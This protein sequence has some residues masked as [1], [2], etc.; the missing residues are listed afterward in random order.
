MSP[1]KT[2]VIGLGSM[3]KNHARILQ[4]MPDIELVGLV[5]GDGETLS[6]ASEAFSCKGYRTIEDLPD[7][8]I[9]YAVVA[10]PNSAHKQATCDMLDRQCHVLVEKPIAPTVEEALA[11]IEKAKSVN[12][13][14]MVGHVERFNPAVIAAK[15]AL[16]GETPISIAINRVGPFPARMSDVGVVIDLAVHDIDIIRSLAQSELATVSAVLASAK[17][18]R[19]DTAFLQFK[20]HNGVVASINTNWVTPFR[21]RQLQIA[22]PT[23]FI[24]AD[25]ITRQAS[26][27]SDYKSDG[28]YVTKPLFITPKEPLVAQHEAS[29]ASIVSNGTGHVSGEDGLANLRAAVECLRVGGY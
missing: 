28:S 7:S 18:V 8:Q 14:L 12:K 2:V 3:G 13:L 26:A 17:A 29:I 19:E 11:M 16:G 9:D 23:K 6:K 4:M 25:L 21:L 15:Q 27:L 20:T 1:I 24:T 10:V 22:T 5:D